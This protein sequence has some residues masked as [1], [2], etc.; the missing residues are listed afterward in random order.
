MSE[1]ERHPLFLRLIDSCQANEIDLANIEEF[2]ASPSDLA[3]VL[4]F[5]GDPVRHPEG[6]DV[7]VVL[8]ELWREFPNQCRLGVVTTEAEMPLA[9]R[10]GV[11]IRPTLVFL[12]GGS[13]VGQIKGMQD[14]DVFVPMFAEGLAKVRQASNKITLTSI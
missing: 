6:L 1:S 7:A 4:F 9:E 11:T 13:V 14:W 3:T 8:P 12:Q 5:T 10:F 2:L